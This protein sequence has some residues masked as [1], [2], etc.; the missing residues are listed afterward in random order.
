MSVSSTL[1]LQTERACLL[2][3]ERYDGESQTLH[4]ASIPSVSLTLN[5]LFVQVHAQVTLCFSTRSMLFL[6]RSRI[7]E[8]YKN[9]MTVY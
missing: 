4:V 9:T 5:T 3:D 2:T 6:T 1:S 8:I 7:S